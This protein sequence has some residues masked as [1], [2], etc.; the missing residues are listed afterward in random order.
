MHSAHFS[1]SYIFPSYSTALAL[2]IYLTNKKIVITWFSFMAF[3]ADQS[4]TVAEVVAEDGKP[5]S[6]DTVLSL[7]FPL[8]IQSFCIISLTECLCFMQPLF[9]IVP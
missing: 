7:S 3:Q 5:V 2:V 4:G 9:V 6:V 1:V 8:S